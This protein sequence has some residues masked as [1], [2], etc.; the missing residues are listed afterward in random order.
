MTERRKGVPP[1]PCPHCEVLRVR[2]EE[3]ERLLSRTEKE[4]DTAQMMQDYL[5][6][7]CERLEGE[8]SAVS[9]RAG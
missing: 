6:M 2:V 1:G 4:R 3:L 7:R 8:R 5:C 9:G